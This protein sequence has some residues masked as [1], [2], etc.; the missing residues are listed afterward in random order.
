M[1]L[2]HKMGLCVVDPSFHCP[3]VQ[4]PQ[5]VPLFFGGCPTEMVQAQKRGLCF[6]RVTEQ[7]RLEHFGAFCQGMLGLNNFLPTNRLSVLNHQKFNFSRG[8]ESNR[9]QVT[10]HFPFGFERLGFLGYLAE[11]ESLGKA[12][13]Q[14]VF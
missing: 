11:L 1:A 14:N 4:W 7:L 12:K 8:A 5:C 3:V 10:S 2:S 6:S 13:Y 9:E